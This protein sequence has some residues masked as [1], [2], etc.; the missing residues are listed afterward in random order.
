M[1]FFLGWPEFSCVELT[2]PSQKVA[3]CFSRMINVLG[4]VPTGFQREGGRG[5]C[6]CSPL[7]PSYD[8]FLGNYLIKSFKKSFSAT[9][10]LL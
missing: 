10:L 8:I 3:F 4:S 2:L 6:F 9:H 5:T 7:K 1:Q